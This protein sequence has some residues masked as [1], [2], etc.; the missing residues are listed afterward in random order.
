MFVKRSKNSRNTRPPVKHG[1]GSIKI[2]SGFSANG[3][4][5]LHDMDGNMD[6]AMER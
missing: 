6:G 2:Q 4:E 5:A 3:T 1:D